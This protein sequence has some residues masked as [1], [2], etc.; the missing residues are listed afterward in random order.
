MS[1]NTVRAV[2]Y[3]SL[4]RDHSGYKEV[5]VTVDKMWTSIILHEKSMKHADALWQSRTLNMD[6]NL[7]KVGDRRTV[8]FLTTLITQEA[9]ELSKTS[10]KISSRKKRNV[11]SC[12]MGSIGV[13]LFSLS[14][15]QTVWT[16]RKTLS[17][18][19]TGFQLISNLF[20]RLK[21]YSSASLKIFQ[22]WVCEVKQNSQK[23]CRG[24]WVTGQHLSKAIS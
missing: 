7:R 14:G 19:D 16:G 13:S 2:M 21:Q 23:C 15:L 9:Q 5:S 24:C 17:A 4:Y 11:L 18:Y 20:C 1:D 3:F 12:W 10:M 6:S 22:Q 8:L